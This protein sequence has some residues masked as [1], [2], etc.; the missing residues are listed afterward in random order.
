LT[1]LG[2]TAKVRSRRQLGDRLIRRR[3]LRS[4]LDRR[5]TRC[6]D[7]ALQR[8]RIRNGFRS[9]HDRSDKTKS[10]AVHGTDQALLLASVAHRRAG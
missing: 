8:R 1:A 5:R 9:F 10:S 7:L 4:P 3:E 6:D 2:A